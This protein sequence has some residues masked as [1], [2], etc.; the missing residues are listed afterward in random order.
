MGLFGKAVPK[1]VENFLMLSVGTLGTS[2]DSGVEL[3]Y[4]GNAFHRIL[5]GFMCQGG[6]GF[7]VKGSGFGVY[8]L[9]PNK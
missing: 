2:P 3:T 9:G 8:G 4:K 7:R 5:P 6:N 1:T